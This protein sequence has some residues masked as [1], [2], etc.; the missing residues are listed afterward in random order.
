[1]ASSSVARPYDIVD[2]DGASGFTGRLVVE[3]LLTNGPQNLKLAIAGRNHSKLLSILESLTTTIPNATKTPILIA[4]SSD[5]TSLD[6]VVSQTKVV[7]TT[8]PFI[9][10]IIDEFHELAVKNNVRIIPS[11]GFDSIPSDI[12]ALLLTDHFAKKNLKTKSVRLSTWSFS[13]GPSGGTIHS[14]MGILELP[15]KTKRALMNP[16]YLVDNKEDKTLPKTANSVALTY[17][18]DLKRWQTYFFMEATNTR[19]VRRSW[20]LLQ[21]SYGTNFTYMETMSQGNILV[22][23]LTVL[24]IGIAGLFILL[25]PV[26]WGIKKLMPQGS[27]PSEKS[28]K[29]GFFYVKLVGVAEDGSKALATVKGIQDPGYRETAKMLSESALTLVVQRSALDN[30]DKSVVGSFGVLKGGILTAASGLGLAV[31]E[32]LRKAGMTFDVEDL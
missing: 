25:P 26:R 15:F 7:L 3:Y 28:M 5:I 12:G 16:Y 4:D 31:A 20:T 22:A 17:D 27:G 21:K 23:L 8:P 9:R 30:N 10:E 11:C 29:E 19:Y 18:K 14:A 1:M 32:R 2:R 6:A 13:G 24:S